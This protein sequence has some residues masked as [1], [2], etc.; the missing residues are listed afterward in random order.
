MK[1][2]R[3]AHLTV[4]PEEEDEIAQRIYEEF[5][6]P[7][8]LFT[9]AD[10]HAIAMEGYLA[11]FWRPDEDWRLRSSFQDSN[12]FIAEFKKRHR[13]SGRR[14]HCKRRLVADPRDRNM[15]ALSRAGQEFYLLARKHD[16]LEPMKRADIHHLRELVRDREIARKV[17]LPQEILRFLG[18][19]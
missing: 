5:S 4:I 11:R 2:T 19:R 10:F 17:E 1:K 7:R 14:A 3:I 6:I 12:G 8:T 18:N 9:D 13:F 15:A 16:R